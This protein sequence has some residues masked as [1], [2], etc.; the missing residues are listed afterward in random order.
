MLPGS[1]MFSGV[2]ASAQALAC[3]VSDF[4]ADTSSCCPNGRVTLNGEMKFFGV[5]LECMFPVL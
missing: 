4:Q 3:S 5:D 2:P 1:E